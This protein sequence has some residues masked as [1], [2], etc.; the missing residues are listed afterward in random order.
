MEKTEKKE[1]SLHKGKSMCSVCGKK[2]SS[3]E[4]YSRDLISD[5]IICAH[6]NGYADFRKSDEATQKFCDLLAQFLTAYF[7]KA[8]IKPLEYY[9]SLFRF[10]GEDYE[11]PMVQVIYPDLQNL[12]PLE[13]R[14]EL[15]EGFKQFLAEHAE[16]VEE[17]K[18]L[19]TLQRKFRF[20]IQRA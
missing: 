2:I 7:H 17:F 8:E 14:D 13:L 15:E 3:G 12:N 6:C 5:E 19:R 10:P 16:N 20:V 18:A 9:I 4:D 11:E 1:R